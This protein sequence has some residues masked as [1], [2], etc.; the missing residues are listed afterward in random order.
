VDKLA[1]EQEPTR[2]TTA[3]RSMPQPCLPKPNH[4][5][6]LELLAAS[7]DGCTE[8]ILRARGFSTAQILDLV[9]AGLATAH[10]QRVI[11]GGGGRRI[12]VARVRITEAGR[13]AILT[14]RWVSRVWIRTPGESRFGKWVRGTHDER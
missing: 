4:G 14:H 7:P 8:A 3:A 13:Q 1:S 11:V 12:E 2:F 9:R 10:S 5:R 6:A